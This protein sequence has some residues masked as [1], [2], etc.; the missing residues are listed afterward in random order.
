MS[1]AAAA[2]EIVNFGCRLNIDGEGDAKL[3]A[4]QLEI[5]GHYVPGNV[6]FVDGLA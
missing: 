1:N 4:G 5:V 2:P 6:G 3:A